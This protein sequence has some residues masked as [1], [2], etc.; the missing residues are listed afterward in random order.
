MTFERIRNFLHTQMLHSFELS[1][2][3][4]NNECMDSVKAAQ[5]NYQYFAHMSHELRTPFHGVMGSLQ[6]LSEGGDN[7]TAAEKKEILAGKTPS[8]SRYRH[9]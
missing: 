7:L 8:I 9:L 6:L 4:T 1:L 2:E 5:E 3:R